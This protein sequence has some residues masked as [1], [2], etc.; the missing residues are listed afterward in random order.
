MILDPNEQGNSGESSKILSDK[1]WGFCE[2]V[3]YH[4]VHTRSKFLSQFMD[5]LQEAELSILSSEECRKRGKSLD[6]DVNKEICAWKKNHRK[7][8]VFEIQKVS[9]GKSKSRHFR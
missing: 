4:N 7:V 1:N 3:C 5:K 6:V 9:N 8:F 2:T